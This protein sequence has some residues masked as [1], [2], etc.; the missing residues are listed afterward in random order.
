MS[1][2]MFMLESHL[3]ASQNRVVSQ[4]QAAAAKANVN[5]F[6]TGGAVRD[7]LGGFPIRDL[8]FRVEGNALKL[9]KVLAESAS[10]RIVSV[11]EQRRSAE[12]V[13]PDR[14]TA[15]ISMARQERYARPGARPTVTPAT[16]QEDLCCRDFTINALALSLNR[17]SLGLL[18]DPTNGLA[19]LEQ[20]ELRTAYPRALYDDPARLLRLIR[21]KVRFSMTIEPRTAQQYENARLEEMEQLIAP[22]RVFEELVQ[23]A[24]EA[25]PGE[26]LQALSAEGLLAQIL[27]K[28]AAQKLNLSGFARLQK[29]RQMI[30]FGGGVAVNNLPLFLY[31]LT[32]NLS[33][34]ERSALVKA[35]SVK[36]SE[37]DLVK[38]LHT[39]AKRLERELRSARVAK[40]SQVYQVLV[41]APGE[42]ILYLF[43]TSSQRQVQDRIRNFFQRYLPAAAEITDRQVSAQ[44]VEPA[45][46]KFKKLK[47]ELILARLDGRAKKPAEPPSPAEA[48]P[49]EPAAV[50][51]AHARGR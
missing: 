17:A 12:M 6:L 35:A 36:K 49:A 32:E 15:E 42:Q 22:R 2:Y 44:G 47:S 11:D 34:A 45:S 21:F 38:R 5:L 43:L 37:L 3:S 30:P 40:P 14:V 46:P 1:D 10:A 48:I 9:A 27:P 51:T 8:D 24:E 29:A 50:R 31:L 4:V 41:K 7:M 16:I 25:D 18:L 28:A 13:F 33:A 19:D 20:K 39:D 23:V 26:V